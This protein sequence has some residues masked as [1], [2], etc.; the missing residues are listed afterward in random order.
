MVGLS[1][2]FMLSL[3]FIGLPLRLWGVD[4]VNPANMKKL[5]R[6]GKNIGLVPGGFE[7]ATITVKDELRVYIK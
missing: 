7:E 2:R 5:M 6:E 1:S 4:A 3:P